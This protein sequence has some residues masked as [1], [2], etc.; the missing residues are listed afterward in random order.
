MSD[1]RKSVSERVSVTEEI[2]LQPIDQHYEKINKI[3]ENGESSD[4]SK[5]FEEYEHSQQMKEMICHFE[6]SEV[7]TDTETVDKLS[8]QNSFKSEN[9]KLLKSNNIKLNTL[10]KEDWKVQVE[11]TIKSQ[12]SILKYLAEQNFKNALSPFAVRTRAYS[13]AVT[14]SKL[15][16]T[17]STKVFYSPV[18][19]FS[20]LTKVADSST[21]N[22]KPAVKLNFL[23]K[24]GNFIKNFNN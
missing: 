10:L 6:N 19:E 3:I 8:R 17:D 24:S 5:F 4:P 13:N 2:F 12:K 7:S 22:V 9:V 20:P 1:L 21:F 18:P 14:P 16:Y 15:V 11:D 23:S